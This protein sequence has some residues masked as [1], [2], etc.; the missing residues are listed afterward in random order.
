MSNGKRYE[1][2]IKILDGTLEGL[3]ADL[4]MT[5]KK[6]KL[7]ILNGIMIIRITYIFVHLVTMLRIMRM[8]II[9]PVGLLFKCMMF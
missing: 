3:V 8:P 5:G 7:A 9:V 2:A 4:I 1:A 6:H